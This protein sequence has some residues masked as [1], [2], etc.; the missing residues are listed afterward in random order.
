MLHAIDF[1]CPIKINGKDINLSIN[2]CLII[3]CNKIGM[4]STNNNSLV[5]YVKLSIQI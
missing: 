1:Y 5:A 4:R 2:L 3:N